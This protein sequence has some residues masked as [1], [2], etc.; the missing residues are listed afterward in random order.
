MVLIE[1]NLPTDTLHRMSTI[2]TSKPVCQTLRRN[3]R[4]C[5]LSILHALQQYTNSIVSEDSHGVSSLIAILSF[6]PLSWIK[7]ICEVVKKRVVL[8]TQGLPR[9]MKGKGGEVPTIMAIG[10]HHI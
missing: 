5:L 9:I 1:G 2:D 3:I 4:T 10:M 7:L 8:A 6:M